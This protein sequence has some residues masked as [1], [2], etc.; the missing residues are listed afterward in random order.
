MID[1]LELKLL[2]PMLCSELEQRASLLELTLVPAKRREPGFFF[3]ILRQ[4]GFAVKCYPK[5][6]PSIGKVDL[7]VC[8][9]I[10]NPSYWNS[11]P[12]FYEYIT[13]LLGAEVVSSSLVRRVDLALDLPE[14]FQKAIQRI[15]VPLKRNGD[16][17]QDKNGILT[18]LRFGS[19]D[20]ATTVYDKTKEGG[21]N[22]GGQPMNVLKQLKPGT[23]A[24]RIELSLTR[25][26]NISIENLGS[27][28]SIAAMGNWIRFITKKF[29]ALDVGLTLC[30][31]PKHNRC[32]ELYARY[33]VL[34][35]SLETNGYGRTRR[36]LNKHRNFQRQYARP[37]LVKV[38][39]KKNLKL[40]F[41]EGLRN[42]CL[43][44][45]E[46]D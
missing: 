25:T 22:V 40:I 21:N 29:T 13:T 7:F 24:T 42:F 46:V 9:V 33:E 38:P 18:G 14:E 8:K 35:N 12:E 36:L 17:F 43:P 37:F 41:S 19:E 34:R 16:G 45:G 5:F 11:F 31:P 23:P 6:N 27:L 2:V 15:E 28:E 30:A 44:Q 10:G 4:E 3:E 20:S 1:K 39:D 32:C 26:E